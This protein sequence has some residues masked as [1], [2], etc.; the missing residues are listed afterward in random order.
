MLEVI[1]SS[2]QY[3]AVPETINGEYF[4]VIP[5]YFSTTQK[6]MHEQAFAEYLVFEDKNTAWADHTEWIEALMQTQV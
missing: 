1:Y 3:I 6:G 5:P 4:G 2:L